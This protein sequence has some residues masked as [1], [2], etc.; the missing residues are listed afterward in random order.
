[1]FRVGQRVQLQSLSREEFNGRFAT[2]SRWDNSR[3]RWIVELCEDNHELALKME[4]LMAA[5]EEAP[6]RDTT[7]VPMGPESRSRSSSAGWTTHGW[8]LSLASDVSDVI[9]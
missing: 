4:N 2:C 9:S 3:G 6:L 1:M 5:T 7:T 8:L